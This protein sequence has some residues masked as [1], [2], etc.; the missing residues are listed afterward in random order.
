MPRER[1]H[2]DLPEIRLARSRIRS[3]PGVDYPAV[4]EP[5]VPGFDI[6]RRR[7]RQR[8][9]DRPC[10]SL[11][12]RRFQRLLDRSFLA[13]A[14]RLVDDPPPRGCPYRAAHPT[15]CVGRKDT[16]RI[17]AV[18]LHHPN[19]TV[20]RIREG[21]ELPVG[22]DARVVRVLPELPRCA[23]HDRVGPYGTLRC[24]PGHEDE[25]APVREPL[26]LPD[27]FRVK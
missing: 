24:S 16:A 18:G 22:R 1:V 13:P 7:R 6:P 27:V 5:A 12:V 14:V 10:L 4:A 19:L 25:P 8:Y 17:L 23:A 26:N 3:G 9:D 2:A 20:L 21:D 11:R 15:P